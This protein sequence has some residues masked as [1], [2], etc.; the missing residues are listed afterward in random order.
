MIVQ[1]I[2]ANIIHFKASQKPLKN[3]YR[4]YWLCC[5]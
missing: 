1:F 3:F 5:K 2:I 4:F